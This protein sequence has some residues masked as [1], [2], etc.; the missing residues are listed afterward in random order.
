MRKVNLES[1]RRDK[2]Y[3]LQVRNSD[4]RRYKREKEEEKEEEEGVEGRQESLTLTFRD[5]QKRE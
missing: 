1:S 2:T 3:A 5:P 4:G